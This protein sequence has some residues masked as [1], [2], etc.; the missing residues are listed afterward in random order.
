MHVSIEKQLLSFGHTHTE[1]ISSSYTLTVTAT[2][3]VYTMTSFSHSGRRLL[4]VNGAADVAAAAATVRER[5][6]TLSF[7]AHVSTCTYVY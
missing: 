2:T 4:V 6:V 3:I 1:A 7:V 5:I